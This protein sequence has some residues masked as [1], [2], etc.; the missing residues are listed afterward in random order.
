MNTK[1]WNG[2]SHAVR[3][4]KGLKA[5]YTTE[6]RESNDFYA[7][8]PIA[9]DIL[10]R[11]FNVLKNYNY[12]NEVIWECAAGTGNLSNRLIELGYNVYATDLMDRG[13]DNIYSGIDFLKCKHLPYNCNIILTNQ[14]FKY[15][16]EFAQK[17]L[18]LLPDGGYY[19]AFMNI[20]YIT[21]Q[22][23]YNSIYR[24]GNLIA[25]C[26]FVKRIECWRNN[27]KEKYGGRA[28]VDFAWYIF[29][30][31]YSGLPVVYWLDR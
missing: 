9:I 12:S 27:D 5:N 10:L 28:M 23:R 31:G 11:D 16:T 25:F 1:D 2:N 4:S 29:K 17:A 20:S 22:K 8:D 7:T 19:I 6:D 15:A 30:K 21:G 14:P 3:A 24:H 18:E 26:P 13:C